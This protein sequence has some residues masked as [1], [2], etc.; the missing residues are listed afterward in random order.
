DGGMI[1]MNYAERAEKL[2]CL[3]A[4]GSKTK[5][6]HKVVGCNFRLDAIQ[7][8]VV[9]AKLPH[10]DSWTAGRQRNAER[11]DG[12]F[13]ASGLDMV[14]VP[15]VVTDRHIFNQYVIRVPRRDELK[16]ALQRKG[17][18]TEVYYPVPMHLQ[19]CFAYLGHTAGAFPESEAAA[20]ETLALPVYPELTDPQARYVVECIQEFFAAGS[21]SAPRRA[22][23]PPSKS[24][25]S[26]SRR[27]GSS[28]GKGGP[29]TSWW[30]RPTRSRTWR[31]DCSSSTAPGSRPG[32][33][34]T[35]SWRAPGGRAN[36]S[37]IAGASSRSTTKSR[38]SKCQPARSRAS[39]R[40]TRQQGSG[41][42][43]LT[44]S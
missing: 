2:V 4:H 23:G 8:A 41:S 34:G 43:R 35:A 6:H 30:P 42:Q 31:L 40:V 25:S 12:L 29:T 9:S 26:C 32:T 33:S 1:V 37:D 7:A 11:Y 18:G 19:E 28:T 17:V 27:R 22:R 16:A 39:P 3:R 38:P 15:K 14:S 36:R 13:A 5:Y 24:S 20:N 21:G 10:L 44:S